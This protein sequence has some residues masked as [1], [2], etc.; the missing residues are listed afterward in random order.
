MNKTA[1]GVRYIPI[2]NGDINAG[3]PKRD[4]TIVVNYEAY[5]A[6]T[7]A[8][9]DSSYTRGE[10]SVYDMSDLIDGWAEALQLMNPGDEWLVFVP[11]G[12]AFGSEPLG[13]LVYRVELEG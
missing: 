3:S 11:A 9:I 5:L 1:S 13:D 8:L 7:G 12:E 6:E 10:S 2:T 4:A